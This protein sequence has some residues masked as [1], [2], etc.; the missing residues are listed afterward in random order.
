[1]KSTILT[2]LFATAIIFGSCNN[3]NQ[4]NVHEGHNMN[5]MS[6]DTSMHNSSNDKMNN[7]GNDSMMHDSTTNN[8]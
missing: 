1:M 4:K 8:R 2:I 7:M 5:G 3:N 6:N